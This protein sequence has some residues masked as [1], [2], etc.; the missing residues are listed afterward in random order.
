MERK[1]IE[2]LDYVKAFAI[3]SVLLNHGAIEFRGMNC[4]TMAVFF[5]SS[6]Y[7]YNSDKDSFGVCFS[8]KLKRLMVPFFIAMAVSAVLEAIRAPFIGYGSAK[9]A[10]AVIANLIYGS[11][12]F[13]NIGS[14]GQVLMDIP[15]FAYNSKYMIDIIMPTNCQMWTLPAMFF[16]YMFFYFYRKIVKKK[17]NLTDIAAILVLLLLTS[18]ETIPGIFQLPFGIG[19]GFFCAA[20]MIVGY[21]FREHRIFEDTNIVRIILMM[22]LSVA[23]T[24]I[25][26]LLGSDATGMVISNYGPYGV[27]SVALTFLCGLCS[28]YVMIMICRFIHSLSIKPVN[29]MLAVVGRNTMEIYLWHFVVIFIFDVIFITLFHPVLSPNLFYS[30]VFSEGYLLYRI[31]RTV[32]TVICLCLF[33]EMK[34]KWKAGKTT[35]A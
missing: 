14:L 5:I 20:F 18:I 11:G 7:T 3:I 24:V 26:V 23:V 22:I 6:G 4:F 8:K 28:G 12:L 19:R 1:R 2:Y 30:E 31:I 9:A 16:G 32:L 21:W 17:S 25:S 13:P 34:T 27:L 29:Y 15:P 33:G 10:I 35:I